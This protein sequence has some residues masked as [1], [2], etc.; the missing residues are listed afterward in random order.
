MFKIILIHAYPVTMLKY[1]KVE[2]SYCGENIEGRVSYKEKN[3]CHNCRKLYMKNLREA[4]QRKTT[5]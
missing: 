3:R 1:V 2:C 4:N 5:Q